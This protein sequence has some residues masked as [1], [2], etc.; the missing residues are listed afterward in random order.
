ML[1]GKC[2]Y[3]LTNRGTRCC[4][5]CELNEECNTVCLND[6]T[7]CGVLKECD[8]RELSGKFRKDWSLYE[9]R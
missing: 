4:C 9:K 8:T 7:K 3:K 5:F 6:V 1:I 2:K